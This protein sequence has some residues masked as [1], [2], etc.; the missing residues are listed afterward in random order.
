M[1]EKLLHYYKIHW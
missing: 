1:F